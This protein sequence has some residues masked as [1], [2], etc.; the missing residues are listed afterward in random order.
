MARREYSAAELRGKLSVK[1][2]SAAAIAGVLEELHQA[3][4]QNDGRYAG[5]VV[6]HQVG[7]GFGPL[8][9]RH[10]LRQAG[11]DAATVPALIEIDWPMALAAT[12]QKKYGDTYPGDCAEYAQRARFL[13][14]RGF[15]VEQ[16]RDF[17]KQ[18]KRQHTCRLSE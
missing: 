15:A 5:S 3:G 1:G 17:F 16:I 10:R 8:A 2:Y 7:R 4:W 12:Y 14:N 9:I 13:Q 6:R 11:V 18:L